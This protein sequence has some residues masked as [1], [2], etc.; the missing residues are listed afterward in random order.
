MWAEIPIL[1]RLIDSRSTD[2]NEKNRGDWRSRLLAEIALLVALLIGRYE[3]VTHLWVEEDESTEVPPRGPRKRRTDVAMVVWGVLF[4]LG[5]GAA[6][7]G[8]EYERVER[9][10]DNV[11]P[12]E[13]SPHA[14]PN[15]MLLNAQISTILFVYHVL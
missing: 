12:H 5:C 1:R 15:M 3:E 7:C 4:F 10:S 14:A 9:R 11:S 2:D 8:W 6:G 13:K